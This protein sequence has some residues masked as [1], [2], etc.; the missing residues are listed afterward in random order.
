MYT[1]IYVA[2]F[3]MDFINSSVSIALSLF[4]AE[5]RG[6]SA[7]IIGLAGF[8]A[9]FSYT[10]T[11]FLKA[12]FF[13]NKRNRWFI[14]TPLG[15]GILY[16][17]LFLVPVPVVLILL[18]FAGFLYGIFWPSIQYCFSGEAGQKKIGI[19]N[20]CWSGGIICGSFLAGHMY[21]FRPGAPFILALM[22]GLIAMSALSI[23]K[24]N[25]SRLNSLPS[26]SSREIKAPL[27]GIIEIRL[28]SFFHLTVVGAIMFLFPKLGLERSFSP[29]IIGIMFG[30]LLLCRF[31]T[32]AILR[33]KSILL[34]RFSFLISCFFFSAGCSLAGL[35]PHPVPILAGMIIIGITGAFSYHNSLILHIKY[36]LPTEIH[37]GIIGAGLFLGP[38][39]AGFLGYVL[40]IPSAFL[41]ISIL[42]FLAGLIHDIVKPKDS[43]KGI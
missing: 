33:K 2:A 13:S 15:A 9:G 26:G 4:L 31:L 36:N 42:I 17:L 18:L 22:L 8:V 39:L 30:T 29:Q 3:L 41:I 19:F 23:Q 6:S 37:E 32:F 1:S 43:L 21:A 40:N 16:F 20:L 35:S 7:L 5:V 24:K 27:M 12:H 25:I 10:A 14:Y 38:L 11:T 28:L 34:H